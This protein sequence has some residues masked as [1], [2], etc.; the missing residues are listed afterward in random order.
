MSARLTVCVGG[1]GVGKT[2]TSAAL[3]LQLAR[4]GA[5][6]LVLTVDPARRL[7]DALGVAIGQ[8]AAPV[9]I[10]PHAAGR[11]FARMPDTRGS[12]GELMEWVFEDPEPRARVLSNP[13]YREL[14]DALAGM[15][16]LLTVTLLQHEA[17]SGRYDEI[18]LDTAPSRNAL[19]FLTFPQR[20]L[21]LLEAKALGWLAALSG[22]LQGGPPS[23]RRGRLGFFAWGRA[24]VESLFG[25]I[26]GVEALRNLS[27]LF[28]ELI[29][30]RGRWAE[31]VRE[32]DRLLRAPTTRY[33]VVGAPSGGAVSDVLFLLGALERRKVRP[34]A[35]VLNRSEAGVPPVERE[36][37]AL[38]DARPGL[39]PAA[40]EAALRGALQGLALEHRARAAS[41]D[42]AARALA[43]RAPRGVP[44]YR[45]P[46]VGPASPP[47]IVLGLADAWQALFDSRPADA[48]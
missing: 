25:R 3:A 22:G 47:E 10:C 41:A 7:A 48:P 26:V 28:A 17:N 18:V 13:A 39:V 1:G 45:L 15:H 6:T 38:L 23:S 27:A 30:A 2:T 44:L 46:F 36:V 33:F 16:E 40:D 5:R 29:N 42:A 19:A 31:L 37:Q 20:F 21:E 32:S 43:A 8:A 12:M 9:T 4:A 14:A 24:K 34:A 35:V 11:F